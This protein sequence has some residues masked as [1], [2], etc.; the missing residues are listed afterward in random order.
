MR[1]AA[2]SRSVLTFAYNL[3][4]V[5]YRIKKSKPTG[6][7]VAVWFNDQILVV[8]HSYRPGWSLPG[9]RAKKN[10]DPRVTASREV[11]EEVGLE[12]APEKLVLVH[13]N[14][15]GQSLFEYRLESSL[16][17]QI[18]NIEIIEAKF[19]NPAHI[20]DPNWQLSKYLNSGF[21]DA[22]NKSN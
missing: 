8:R 9:G 10:E 6:A 11:A 2:I 22:P 18:D 17:P 16:Q 20:S 7:G 19:M 14:R 4:R 21:G 5:W 13:E 3:L 12:L 1:S 15:S